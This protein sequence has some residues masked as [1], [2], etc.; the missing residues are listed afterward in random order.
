[1]LVKKYPDGSGYVTNTE[2]GKQIFRINSYESLW[3]LNQFVDAFHSEWS[4]E[5]VR[6]KPNIIIPNLLDAQADRRFKK[7]E[8]SGLKL[9]CKF[10][11]SL[12]ANFEIFHPHNPE[13]VEAL[14]DNVKIKDNSDFITTVLHRIDKVEGTNLT[15]NQ[16]KGGGVITTTTVNNTIL[17]SSD[18]GG[19]KPLMKL[20][21]KLDWKGETFSASKARTK[22]GMKQHIGNVDFKGKD[23]LIIDDMSVQGGTF[24]GLASILED[25]NIGKLYLAVSHMSVQH[26]GSDPVTDYF[27]TVFTTNSKFDKYYVQARHPQS[28][29]LVDFPQPQNLEIINLF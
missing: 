13:V 17:M 8:S 22:D 21:D 16:L 25:H 27:D 4:T 5:T 2:L 12:E 11:N 6:V 15:Y 7:G 28:K 23:I 14:M 1:M 26:L 24:K 3:H 18:A 9:V 20:C 10:L 19:F 29:K